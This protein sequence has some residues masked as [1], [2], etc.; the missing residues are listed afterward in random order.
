MDDPRRLCYVYGMSGSVPASAAGPG[1]GYTATEVARL[2]EVPAS[3]VHSW[4]RAG[5]V[6]P[7]RGARHELRFSFPDLV[8]LRAAK[9]LADQVPPRRVRRALQ[10][11]REQ[12]PTGRGLAGVRFSVQGEDIVVHDGGVAWE[13]ESGQARLDFDAPVV[14]RTAALPGRRPALPAATPSEPDAE[15]WF[16]RGCETEAVDPAEARDAYRRALELDPAHFDAR[17]NL[18]RL[19]HEAGE[20]AAAEANYRLALG[21][22]PGDATASFN[23]G[24]ALEDL[25]RLAEAA[26]AYETALHADPDYADAHYNLAHLHEQLGRPRDALRHL[27]Q[28]RNLTGE[29]GA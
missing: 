13:P 10:R 18:G 27:Q 7:R 16:E 21:S 29:R 2:L 8:V 1:L 20:V 23:L 28:Y 19:L 12:L 22:R 3:R 9:T 26:H 5:F 24:V 17:V 11:V 15:A 14:G 4:V 25:R 6:E